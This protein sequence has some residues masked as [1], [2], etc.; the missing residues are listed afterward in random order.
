MIRDSL[1]LYNSL[2][3]KALEYPRESKQP[4]FKI[5]N[6]LQSP[7]NLQVIRLTGKEMQDT[8]ILDFVNDIRNHF[9]GDLIDV[10]LSKKKP[11][12]IIPIISID[13]DIN[14]LKKVSFSFFK[15]DM[16]NYITEIFLYIDDSCAQKCGIC[17]KAYKQFPCCSSNKNKESELNIFEIK[18]LLDELMNSP[19]FNLNILGGNI[20]AYSKFIELAGMINHLPAQKVYYVHYANIL[21]ENGKLKYLNPKSSVL[22]VLAPAP[23]DQDKLTKAVDFLKKTGL[24]SQ[25]I[26]VVQSEDE[27]NKAEAVISA[28]K[29]D[30]ADYQ[31]FYNGNNLEF[32]EKNVF[33]TEEE[34]LGA[35]PGMKD[36]YTNSVVNKLNFGRLTILSNG[37]MYANVN[38]SRLGIIGKDSIY[39]ALYKEM[40]HG[41]SWRRIR[42]NVQP[43]KH[44]TFQALCP[45]LS[46]YNY[47]LGK[48]NL[49]HV[50]KESV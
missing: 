35:K 36:I 34:I 7:K 10:C 22:K 46:N 37:Y 5:I 31:P 2:T 4:I 18:K 27:F 24:A 40:Y 6:R 11:A 29:I 13:S 21:E 32:F 23:L 1:L 3:G 17:N 39:D 33:T 44:C 42:K 49:C 12:Q 15:T 41:K 47:A 19:L 16:K 45:P 20:F 30:N 25:F 38:A 26:F 14:R 48:N 43:C 8:I 50:M 28:L 9:M